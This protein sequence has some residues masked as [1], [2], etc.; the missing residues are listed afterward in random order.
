MKGREVTRI[1][2]QFTVR[3]RPRNEQCING[4][5]PN[6]SSRELA[7]RYS[8]LGQS[9]DSGRDRGSGHLHSGTYAV[10]MA[11]PQD[12][13]DFPLGF[14][15]SEGVIDSAV[16]ISS[17]DN[18]S[19]YCGE[20]GYR[21]FYQSVIGGDGA[22]NRRDWSARDGVGFGSNG[23]GSS[24]GGCGGHHSCR[25]RAGGRIRSVHPSA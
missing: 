14:S 17:L 15:R 22:E 7:G 8:R 5:G 1:C 4:A 19:N 3:Q 16:D 20:R 24:Y 9:L 10:M 2:S 11:T 25:H 18:R 12:L 13:E 6:H 21:A 23:V